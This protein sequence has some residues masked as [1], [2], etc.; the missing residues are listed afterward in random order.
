MR[1]RNCR[2]PCRGTDAGTA[3]TS[4]S[5]D[6]H[7]LATISRPCILQYIINFPESRRNSQR[8]LRAAQTVY[9][10]IYYELSRV[11]EELPETAPCCPN[12]VFYNIFL[13]FPSLGGP[14]SDRSM[15]LRLCILQYIVNFPGSRRSSQR[16]LDAA[17]TMYFII[18]C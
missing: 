2:R 14:P 1:K 15:L 5:V 17:Q 9:F 11:S 12:R 4:M 13:T 8:P 3:L 16:P 6:M 7:G 10:T 18:H